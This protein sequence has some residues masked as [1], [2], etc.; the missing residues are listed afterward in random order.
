[1]A[2]DVKPSGK[3]R[4]VKIVRPTQDGSEF[5]YVDLTDKNLVNSD[6]YYVYNNDVIYV[7]PMKAKAWGIGETFPYGLVGSLLALF[8]TVQALIK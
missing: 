2:G 5:F 7:R 1:M 8:I 6:H 4:Q 3:K